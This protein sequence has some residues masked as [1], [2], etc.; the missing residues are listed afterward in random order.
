MFYTKAEYSFAEATPSDDEKALHDAVA[1]VLNKSPVIL[2]RLRKYAGCEEFIRKV[3]VNYLVF[4]TF[5]LIWFGLWGNIELVYYKHHP[6]FLSLFPFVFIYFS[7]LKAITTPGPE[8]EEAAWEA[9]LPA[10]DQLQQFYDFSLELG[11][12]YI[13]L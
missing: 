5:M 2:D 7:F 8:T 1:E 10:V 12:L 11:K 4:N 6:L 13:F 3:S 9:V